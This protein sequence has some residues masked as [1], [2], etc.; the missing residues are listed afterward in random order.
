MSSNCSGEPNNFADSINGQS[1]SWTYEGC[2]A[3]DINNEYCLQTIPCRAGEQDGYFTSNFSYTICQYALPNITYLP[4]NLPL[5]WSTLED[6]F[7]LHEGQFLLNQNY[8]FY[9]KKGN[10]LTIYVI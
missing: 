5:A 7:F 4:V 9:L 6:D 10:L 2:F 3:V 8:Q 1:S